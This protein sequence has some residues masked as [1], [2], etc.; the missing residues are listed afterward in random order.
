[1]ILLLTFMLL[2]INLVLATEN[3]EKPN[4]IED[5]KISLS[6][7]KTHTLKNGLKINL[8]ERKDYPF[9]IIH[10]YIRGAQ[11]KDINQ[12]MLANIAPRVYTS[13]IINSDKLN[14]FIKN[15]SLEINY[16]LTK[17]Y[18]VLEF[19]F[20]K[21]NLKHYLPLIAEI[22]IKTEIN[23][24]LLQNVLSDRTQLLNSN[25]FK[26]LAINLAG[27]IIFG[28]NH[29]YSYKAFDSGNI[30]INS[31][32]NYLEKY[33][34]PNNSTIIIQGDFK[35]KDMIKQIENLYHNW[36]KT[37]DIDIQIADQK[38]LPKGIHLI[39]LPAK[40]DNTHIYFIFNAP[41]KTD[42][43]YEIL[44]I[45]LNMLTSSDNGFLTKELSRSIKSFK[46]IESYLSDNLF[47][48]FALIGIECN[49]DESEKAIQL[50]KDNIKFISKK[51]PDIETLNATQQNLGGKITLSFDDPSIVSKLIYSSLLMNN[52]IDYYKQLPRKLRNESP[53]SIL[54][55][56]QKYIATEIHWNIVLGDNELGKILERNHNLFIYDENLNPLNSFYGKFEKYAMSPEKLINRY[57]EKI[58]KDLTKLFTLEKNGIIKM[59]NYQNPATEGSIIIKYQVP[60]KM[61]QKIQINEISQE[62]W[63]NGSKSWTNLGYSIEEETDLINESSVL[64]SKIFP[65]TSLIELG[66]K[67]NV[68]GI[69][70]NNIV[71][72][73]ESPLSRKL[74]YY[75]D[76]DTYLLTKAETLVENNL[77]TFLI[78]TEF[79]NYDEFEGFLF[80]K[81]V[82]EKSPYFNI[83]YDFN[84]KINPEFNETTFLPESTDN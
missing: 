71:L 68:L 75:F 34:S 10:F 14:K 55:V 72:K 51:I 8:L 60:D 26:S 27:N 82:I 16:N 67:C 50:I 2:N 42:F 74:Y 3:I 24:D 11:S 4:P 7:I 13:A 64:M 77:N 40:S 6:E 22:I 84:Y 49:K 41:S 65:I 35:T 39:Q 73:A 56:F 38:T 57:K 12:I 18:F 80:P 48:N 5:Y 25:D 32:K 70:G 58:S 83:M 29:N 33:I 31:I 30:N 23:K 61:Y 37:T 36:K 54:K 9:I 63:V 81:S 15:H 53:I 46:G 44:K 79:I 52:S 47:L 66:Y 76:K 1:M 45:I 62:L 21:K 20:L 43:D 17:D 28:T 78:T 69:Q 59:Y 19:K